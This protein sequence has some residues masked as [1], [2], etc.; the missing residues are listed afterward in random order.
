MRLVACSV[1]SENFASDT[2][3]ADAELAELLETEKQW[4]QKVEYA[5]MNQSS[6]TAHELQQLEN[7]LKRI[8]LAREDLEERCKENHE[9]DDD[10]SEEEVVTC[11]P[12]L[13]LS[14]V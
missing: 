14:G 10:E 8:R 3:Q 9:H 7:Q 4:E 11:A 12:W 6:H 2:A 5:K 1:A 13:Y